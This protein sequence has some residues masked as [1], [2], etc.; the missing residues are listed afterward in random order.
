MTPPLLGTWTEWHL[1]AMR[2]QGTVL[3]FAPH[4]DD[5]VIA[6]GGTIARLV[7]E[8]ARVR[9]VF[10]TDGAMSHSAVLG[11]HT[12]PTPAELRTIRRGEA[13]AAARAMGLP[14]G[15]VRFLD[16]PDTRLADHLEEFRTEVLKVLHQYPDA[17]EVY[18]PHE[19]REL[20]ADHRLTGETVVGCLAELGLT[21]TAYRYVVWDE[22]TEQEFAFVNRNPPAASAGAAERLIAADITE[23]LPRKQAALREHRTQVDLFAPG[24]T[25]PVVPE[26]FQ[27]RVLTARVEE[28]WINEP[29]SARPET[30]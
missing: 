14:E 24:Q 26:P 20:N 19:V 1:R 7:A 12:D 5:E 10:A 13:L 6:C 16:F 9:V 3:V 4:P 28:F 17:A 27:E 21:P 18:L 23:Y 2:S 25:R 15:A 22:R 30:E 11:I 8:G 29:A